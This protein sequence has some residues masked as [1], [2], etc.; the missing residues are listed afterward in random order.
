MLKGA[1]LEP[2][3]LAINPSSTVPALVDGDLRLFDSSAIAI[4]LVENYAKNDSLYPKDKL[5]R[6]KVNEKLFYVATSVFPSIFNVFFPVIFQDAIEIAEAS[7]QRLHRVY[8][9]IEMILAE[10][11]FLAGSEITLPDLF[12]WCITESINR[13]VPIDCEK[14]PKYIGWLEKMRKHPC[15]QYQ[16]DGVDLHIQVF[17]MAKE[18]NIKAKQ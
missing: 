9:T 13:V 18:R 10:Q 15:N 12:L 14:H 16:Q 17:E 1:H 11:D 5:K 8:G 3:Y 7:I 4:Y 6:A 2:K